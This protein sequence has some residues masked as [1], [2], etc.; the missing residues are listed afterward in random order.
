MRAA[1][2]DKLVSILQIAFISEEEMRGA[3]VIVKG[4]DIPDDISRH[5][6]NRR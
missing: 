3:L 4:E 1:L 5:G 2:Q 6:E